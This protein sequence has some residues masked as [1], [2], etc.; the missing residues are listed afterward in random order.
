MSQYQGIHSL[1]MDAKGRIAI[2]TRLREQMQEDCGGRIVLT[3]HTENKCLHVFPEA[4]WNSILEKMNSTPSFNQRLRKVKLLLIGY[5]SPFELDESGRLL[6][7]PNLRS[8]AGFDKKLILVGQVNSLE[9][10]DEEA[11]NT[12][13]N[14]PI[15]GDDQLPE[16]M[17]ELALY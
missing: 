12:F 8:Y 9:L 5:A 4:L 7:P 17:Q 11:F 14:A 13:V 3:A 2:P 6:I 1:S 10:W 15:E 16:N